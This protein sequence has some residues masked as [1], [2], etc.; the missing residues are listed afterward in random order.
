[1]AQPI[2]KRCKTP[3]SSFRNGLRQHKD[4]DEP[5]QNRKVGYCLP[6]CA[7]VLFAGIGATELGIP[8]SAECEALQLKIESEKLKVENEDG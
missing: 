6:D 3:K 7:A 1:M 5:F 2:K 8:L 4:W